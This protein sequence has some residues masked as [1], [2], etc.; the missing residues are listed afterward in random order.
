MEHKIPGN[1]YLVEVP[2][3]NAAGFAVAEYSIDLTGGPQWRDVSADMDCTGHVK[4][5]K[6]IDKVGKMRPFVV[7]SIPKLK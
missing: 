2:S 5:Y 4:S 6:E 3:W 1:Y 7:L